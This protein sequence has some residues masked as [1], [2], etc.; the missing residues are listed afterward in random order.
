MA[1]RFDLK[2]DGVI[3]SVLNES[4]QPLTYAEGSIVMRL[5]YEAAM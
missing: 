2:R 4:L 5:V 1:C 3:E